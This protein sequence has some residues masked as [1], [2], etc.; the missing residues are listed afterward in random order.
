M[1]KNLAIGLMFALGAVGCGGGGRHAGVQTYTLVRNIPESVLASTCAIVEGPYAVPEGA[2]ME[3]YISTQFL[4]DDFDVGVV[5]DRIPG[6]DPSGG[7][8]YAQR[9]QNDVISTGPVPAGSY[10]LQIACY[11]ASGAPCA[12]D[13]S[14]WRATY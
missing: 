14:Y 9:V 12:P 6:C 10:T 2:E 4:D 3:Y 8:G 13:L 11:N 1:T 7:Y 5:D